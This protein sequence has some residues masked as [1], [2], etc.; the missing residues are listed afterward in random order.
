MEKFNFLFGPV[1]SRRFGRSLGVDLVPLKT[2]TTDCVFCE[3]GRTTALSLERREYVPVANVL[4]ELAAWYALGIEADFITLAGSGEPTLHSRFGEVLA[5]VRAQPR[6]IRSALLTNSSLLHL[7]EVRRDAARADV[8]KATL[9]A[10]DQASYA[11]LT[12]PAASLNFERLVEGL[13]QFR[14]EYDGAL[15]LEVFLVPGLN[16]APDAVR[17]IAHLA[18]SIA[19]DRIQLNTAVRPT[20][21]AHVSV[22]PPE[23]LAELAA[24]FE[25]EAETIARFKAEA[26]PPAKLHPAS[27]LAMLRRRPCTA[28]DVVHAFG[29]DAATVAGWLEDWLREG[30]IAAET[31][32]GER[33]YFRTDGHGEAGKTLVTTDDAP[34]EHQ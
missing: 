10:W 14:R 5:A 18:R 33:Y 9:S 34:K 13:R 30:R 7:P 21:D 17:R 12:R 28:D 32:N 1:P 29:V 6:R 22:V 24:L 15:W 26:M 16:D 31:R 4:R 23:R 3:V 8:V 20:A 19:P 11:A 27:A 25:P 2:C